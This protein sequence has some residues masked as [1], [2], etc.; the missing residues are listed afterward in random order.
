MK[1]F[2]IIVTAAAV[3]TTSLMVNFFCIYI[4]AAAVADLIVTFHLFLMKMA[5]V[6]GKKWSGVRVTDYWT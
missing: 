1:K 5:R 4:A 3:I 6:I 2:V